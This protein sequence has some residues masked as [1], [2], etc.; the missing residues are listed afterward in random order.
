MTRRL[1]RARPLG[2]SACGPV[3]EA[4]T[5]D[6]QARSHSPAWGECVRSHRTVPTRAVRG[7]DL[8]GDLL[9][10]LHARAALSL[11]EREETINGDPGLRRWR[12][13]RYLYI[14]TTFPFRIR[15]RSRSRSSVHGSPVRDGGLFRQT[16]RTYRLV[17]HGSLCNKHLRQ[18]D[19]LFGRP[20]STTQRNTQHHID[21]EGARSITA[22]RRNSTDARDEHAA[23]PHV[24]TSD[25]TK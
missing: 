4:R 8:R 24:T 2:G 11:R 17:T 19:S 14:V 7:G 18:S 10:C 5:I 9:A 16:D 15:T 23:E 12:R 13:Q 25:A 22:S 1:D 6:S 3:L 20:S 21:L